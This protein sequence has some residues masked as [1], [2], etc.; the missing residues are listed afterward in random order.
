MA[1]IPCSR[2]IQLRP[3]RPTYLYFPSA[4]KPICLS[5]YACISTSIKIN[6]YTQLYCSLIRVGTTAWRAAVNIFSV[7][8]W[9]V[10][11]MW[12]PAVGWCSKPSG[13][14]FWCTAPDSRLSTPPDH[15][16]H[17]RWYGVAILRTAVHLLLI[18]L[19]T[20]R[21]DQGLDKQERSQSTFE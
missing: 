2:L 3:S 18:Y 20:Y 4:L 13:H 6:R 10:E 21:V 12:I 5:Q 1:L 9:L 16:T 19:L 7:F 11:W 15:R 8:L 17:D 14:L